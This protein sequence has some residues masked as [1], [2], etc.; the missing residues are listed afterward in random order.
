MVE[1]SQSLSYMPAR[2]AA[3]SARSRTD[4]SMPS[5]LHNTREFMLRS[6]SDA[7]ATH[8]PACSLPAR[9]GEE[10]IESGAGRLPQVLTFSRYGK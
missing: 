6:G 3:A 8:A 4:G 5:T 9:P 10:T 7:G 1:F 2:R